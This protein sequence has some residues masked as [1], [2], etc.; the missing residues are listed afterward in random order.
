MNRQRPH[1]R[2][3]RRPVLSRRAVLVGAAA[4]GVSL[5]V[6][7]H[8]GRSVGSGQVRVILTTALG[9]IELAVD[10]RRAPI[11]AGDF[12]RYVDRGLFNGGA[13]YRTVRPDNDINPVKID[14]IQGGVMDESKRLPPIRHEST[15]KTDLRHRNG[16]ISIARKAPGTGTAGAFFICIGDQPQ[17]D[18]GGRRNP[19]RQ[20]FAAFGHVA[21]G[22]DVVH[23]I[24]KSK[25]GVPDGGMG[26]QRLMPPI[27]IVSAKRI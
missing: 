7:A 12:L 10:L 13:F 2:G 16:T 25:T 23:A 14:V 24:W 17:L 1:G 19:D 15:N 11:S 26:A 27:K 18:F 22:M 8:R 20:G 5:P 3:T 4:L 21:R 6:L 9:A